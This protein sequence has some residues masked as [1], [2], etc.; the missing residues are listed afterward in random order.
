MTGDRNIKKNGVAVAWLGTVIMYA[1]NYWLAYVFDYWLAI[2]MIGL[3][4]TMVGCVLWTQRKR[5]HVA[6]ALWGLLAP[7]GFLGI[8]L[9]RDK[10]QDDRKEDYHAGDEERR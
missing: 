4:V 2:L 10:S 8:A 9:L 6:F 7:V 3:A 1:V 5:R